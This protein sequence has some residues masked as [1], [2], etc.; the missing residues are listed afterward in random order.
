MNEAE[1]TLADLITTKGPKYLQKAPLSVYKRLLGDD[2]P[3]R[4]ARILLV[5]V[6]AGAPEKASDMSA[7]ELSSGLQ[8]SCGLR[9]DAAD[10][11]AQ[12]FSRLFLSSG[13]VKENAPEGAAFQDFCNMEWT[14]SWNNIASITFRG[15]TR[16]YAVGA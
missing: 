6:L 13:V 8:E 2:I 16:D 9:K 5:A 3:P 7:A 10:E 1:R 12:L 4:L 15:G 14:Y 11:A